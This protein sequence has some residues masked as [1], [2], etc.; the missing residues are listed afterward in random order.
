[1]LSAAHNMPRNNQIKFFFLNL[2]EVDVTL[3]NSFDS[4]IRIPVYENFQIYWVY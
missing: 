1:M 2:S 3:G 4:K